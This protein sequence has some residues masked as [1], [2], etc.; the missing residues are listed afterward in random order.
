MPA[1]VVDWNRCGGKGTCVNVCQVVV[2]EFQEI[3]KH[4]ET[5][6]AVP[7]NVEN[8]TFCMKCVPACIEQAI[9][10]TKTKGNPCLFLYLAYVSWLFYFVSFRCS[11]FPD[12]V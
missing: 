10:V 1:V 4:Q 6:K 5:V 7:V 3:T 9:I 8:C 11:A 2:F 12:C